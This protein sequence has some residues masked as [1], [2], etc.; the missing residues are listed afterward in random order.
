MLRATDSSFVPPIQESRCL[1][2]EGCPRIL[3]MCFSRIAQRS[4]TKRRN[5]PMKRRLLLTCATVLAIATISFS[6]PAKG[7]IVITEVMFDAKEDNAWQ[8]IEIKNTGA[9]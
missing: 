2:L 6:N 1:G 3:C 8:W 7:Q 5:D 9:S 4:T